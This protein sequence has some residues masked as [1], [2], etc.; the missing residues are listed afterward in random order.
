MHLSNAITILY[1]AGPDPHEPIL[2]PLCQIPVLNP[3]SLNNARPAF[4]LRDI[5]STRAAIPVPSICPVVD[6]RYGLAG[7]GDNA[8]R[9]EHHTRD[10]VIVGVGID[11][12]ACAEIPYLLFTLAIDFL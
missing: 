9:F 8:P 6:L 1:L 5:S 4:T 3:H 11:D 7:C 12:G 2:P 10:R